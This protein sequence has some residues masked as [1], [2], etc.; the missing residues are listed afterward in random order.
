MTKWEISFSYLKVNKA[1]INGNTKNPCCDFFWWLIRGVPHFPHAGGFLCVVFYYSYYYECQHFAVKKSIC[2]STGWCVH[3]RCY[4]HI[5]YKDLRRCCFLLNF[6]FIYILTA[7]ILS[8]L[9]FHV[10][11]A[12][13]CWIWHACLFFCE[14]SDLECVGTSA[15]RQIFLYID[16]AY[17]EPGL[18]WTLFI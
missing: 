12:Q 13:A 6:L 16:L 2:G 1:K 14:Q 3:I 11:H 15:G 7:I 8:W 17:F 10:W 5:L 9:V 4:I 18:C